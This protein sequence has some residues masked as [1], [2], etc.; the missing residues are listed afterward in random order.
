ME[1]VC[2][3][4]T[5]A[6]EIMEQTFTAPDEA[7]LRS[8]LE[9][10]GFYLFSIRRGLR[11]SELR[12]RRKRVATSL[13]LIF[14]QELAALLK[15]GLPLLYIAAAH[16]YRMAKRRERAEELIDRAATEYRRTG[17]ETFT[18]RLASP[19]RRSASSWK[20][21]RPRRSAGSSKGSSSRAPH[22]VCSGSSS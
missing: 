7:A 15:A 16:V 21:D 1:Y 17:E 11:L 9:Q 2:K 20:M 13:L 22:A 8:E 12:L 19:E 14:G 6:G 4:G 5:A 3:V 18:S 10:K